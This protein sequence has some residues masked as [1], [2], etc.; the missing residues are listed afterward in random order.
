[1]Y[2]YHDLIL[3]RSF[4]GIY[5][6]STIGEKLGPLATRNDQKFMTANMPV[7]GELESIHQASNIFGTVLCR[8][9]N[10]EC[11]KTDSKNT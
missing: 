1:M 6:N 3:K 9:A 8:R 5:E 11:K 4:V 10:L 2:L 7:S